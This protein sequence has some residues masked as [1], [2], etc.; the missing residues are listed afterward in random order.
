MKTRTIT[1]IIL[2]AIT[3]PFLALGGFWTVAFM[4]AIVVGGVIEVLRVRGIRWPA[5]VY[6]IAIAG[7]VGMLLWNF[8]VFGIQN[9]SG[10]AELFRNKEALEVFQKSYMIRINAVYIGF[11]LAAL[12]LTECFS[13]R[14]TVSDVFYIF[15]LSLLLGIA[16]QVL[17]Y[18]RFNDIRSIIYIFIGTYACDTFALL[19]GK[20]FGK[21][22]LAPVTSPKKTWEGAIGG[23]AMSTILS[24]G[25][26]CIWPFAMPQINGGWCYLTA[27]ILSVVLG[28]C[29][30]IG[31]L[32]FSSIKRHFGIKDFGSIFPGHGGILDRVD[33][34]LFNLIAFISV[35]AIA[36]GGLLFFE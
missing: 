3:I 25:F 26:Y 5:S 22:K 35:Y 19:C 29:A 10:F 33:S 21:H 16:G 18:L 7:S 23:V 14:F 17:I 27:F 4:C 34:L 9:P 13:S 12:L 15:T 6:I 32:I 2:I 28:C 31:D 11:Y 24:F 20:Y 1:A 8:I 36:T 30:V